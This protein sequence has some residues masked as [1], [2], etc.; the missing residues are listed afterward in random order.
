MSSASSC[1]PQGQVTGSSKACC[2]TDMIK[3]LCEH[4]QICTVTWLI[5]WAPLC[6]TRRS[7]WMHDFTHQHAWKRNCFP[8][9]I[10]EE[11]GG[12]KGMPCPQWDDEL[13]LELLL[14]H[15]ILKFIFVPLHHAIYQIYWT[16]TLVQVLHIHLIWSLQPFWRK[17]TWN[18]VLILLERWWEWGSCF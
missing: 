18:T 16:W 8:H 12:Q 17:C 11:T 7:L 1:P 14:L 3:P 4:K 10:D 9:F 15:Q 5:W 13:G 2:K 6:V